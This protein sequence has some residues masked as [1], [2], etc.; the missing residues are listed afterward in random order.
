MLWE[1]YLRF[2]SCKGIPDQVG[3]DKRGGAGDGNAKASQMTIAWTLS[4]CSKETVFDKMADRVRHN[5]ASLR[6]HRERLFT[7]NCPRNP[8]G[9]DKADNICN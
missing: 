8:R 5:D 3:D 1:S 7:K 9:S 6:H 2:V 4:R